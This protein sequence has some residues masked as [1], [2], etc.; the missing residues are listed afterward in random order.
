MGLSAQLG[1]VAWDGTKLRADA[2]RH[3]AMS[4]ERL[5]ARA[6][7]A[8]R[9]GRAARVQLDGAEETDQAEDAEFGEDVRGNELPA[10][11]AWRGQR[12]ACIQAAKIDPAW[13]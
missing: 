11:L 9:A 10:E 13:R 3:K 7:A 2:S 1:Q 4:Y 5:S 6:L 12:L 8:G